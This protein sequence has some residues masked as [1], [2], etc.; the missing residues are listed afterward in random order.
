MLS[1]G[2]YVNLYK[3]NNNATMLYRINNDDLGGIMNT[4]VRFSDKLSTIEGTVS[5]LV[6]FSQLNVHDQFD[7]LALQ[8]NSEGIVRF[9][10]TRCRTF[11]SENVRHHDIHYRIE[12]RSGINFAYFLEKI[13]YFFPG[14][15][16]HSLHIRTSCYKITVTRGL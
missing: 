12:F 11:R 2:F 8:I 5:G 1:S 14:I 9:A 15:P 6:G 13:R 4:A 16:F 10:K 7:T 3:L